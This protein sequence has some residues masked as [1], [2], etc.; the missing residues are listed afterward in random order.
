MQRP[1]LI[2]S[3]ELAST[4]NAPSTG[5]NLSS[6]IMSCKSHFAGVF[7]TQLLHAY[8]IDEERINQFSISLHL[9]LL[10][11]LF[12]DCSEVSDQST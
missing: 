7:T 3:T 1:R 8:F 4:A 9:P 5:I 2:N 12:G 10:I 6:N 11:F